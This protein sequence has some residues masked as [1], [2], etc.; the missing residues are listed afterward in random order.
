MKTWWIRNRFSLLGVGIVQP[1]SL[2]LLGFTWTYLFF[3]LVFPVSIV[4]GID[5]IVQRSMRKS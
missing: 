2:G 5:W 3:G 4:V 1:F